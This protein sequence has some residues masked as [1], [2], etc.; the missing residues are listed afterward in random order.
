[1]GAVAAHCQVG[2]GESA[3]SGRCLR[4]MR[5]SM[6]ASIVI[7]TKN[8]GDN[9][10]RLLARLQE[11]DFAGE[12]EIIVIDSGSTDG[13]LAAARRYGVR[14][15]EIK[16]EEFHHG[17]TRNLGAALTSGR[18]IVYITQ[19]ALPLR[20]DWLQRLTAP[21][22]EPGVAMVCGRQIAW[23]DTKP[24]EKFFYIYSFPEVRIEVKA[25][26]DPVKDSI[27]I[28][29]VN[30]ALRREA[31]E[32]Y[33]FS[34]KI[35]QAEDK[36]IAKRMIAGGL[37]VIYEPEAPVYHAHDFKLKDLWVRA[38]D[39]GAS[40]AQGVGM[41]RSRHWVRNRMWYYALEARYL[42]GCRRWYKWLPYSAAYEASRLAGVG[43]G[44]G[45]R[46]RTR[47]PKTTKSRL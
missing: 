40:L 11:Q 24:P 22:S 37:T 45:G 26:V 13:T 47:E 8:G 35:V 28:S 2:L 32:K 38:K 43:M 29:D 33:R 21:L 44:W 16:P 19:D 42:L 4:Q 17:R 15:V 3:A 25:G 20:N 36:E 9:F 27:F 39:A 10:P 6:E 41:P 34:E 14:T 7:L 30:S 5:K 18:N 12:H 23:E 31:W 1:V 46:T